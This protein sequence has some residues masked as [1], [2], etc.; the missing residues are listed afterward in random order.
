MQVLSKTQLSSSRHHWRRSR[1]RRCLA[2]GCAFN[3][4]WSLGLLMWGL[5]GLA[6]M[7]AGVDLQQRPRNPKH[8]VSAMEK[9]TLHKMLVSGKSVQST[10]G[11]KTHV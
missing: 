9:A 3:L 10:V 5:C 8:S 6:H 7:Q 4:I 1:R 2:D 11:L